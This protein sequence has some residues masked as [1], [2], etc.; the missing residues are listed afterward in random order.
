M[1]IPIMKILKPIIPQTTIDIIKEQRK[2]EQKRLNNFNQSSMQDCSSWLSDEGIYLNQ[3]PVNQGG[4][5][6]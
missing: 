4:L 1:Q 3:G 5:K 2:Q 6:E